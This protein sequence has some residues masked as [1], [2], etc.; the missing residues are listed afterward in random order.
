MKPP[1][2]IAHRGAPGRR[3]NTVAG[4]LAGIAAGAEW[5]ELDVHRTADGAIVVHHDFELGTRPLAR[6]TLRE[7]RTLARRLKQVKL[8]TLDDVVEALPDRIGLGVEIKA[9]HIA[10]AV[11]CVLAEHRAA[12]RALV[13]SFHWPTVRALAELRP[14]VRSG[15][16]SCSRLLDP[17]GDLRR[18]RAQ[19]LCQEHQLADRALVRAVQ[20]AGFQVFVWTVN[21]TEDLRRMLALGVDAIITDHPARLRRLLAPQQR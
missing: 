14:R 20:G 18:A 6:C 15:L 4:F 11:V 8:P 5:I 3:E 12:D 1:L 9:P 10:R 13:S 19:A 16:L 2:V 7:A 17:V 21:R